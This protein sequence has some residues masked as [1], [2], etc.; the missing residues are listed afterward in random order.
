LIDETPFWTLEEVIQRA[1]DPVVV[2]ST[3]SV[4]DLVESSLSFPVVTDFH[5]L[6][7][8]VTTLIVVGGGTMMDAAKIMSLNDGFD[9]IAIPS[10]WGSGAEVS[11]I[12]VFTENGEKKHI[13]DDRL[14]PMARSSIPGL[15]ERLSES[16]VQYGCGDA[17]SHA[18]EGSVS[19]LGILE[20][21]ATGAALMNEMLEVGLKRDEQWFDFSA[22]ACLLQASTGVG[23][24]HGIAHTL[25]PILG[26]GQS[27]GG[28]GH[29]RL[30]S[31]ILWPVFDRFIRDT[32][33]WQSFTSEHMVDE[34]AISATL[35]SLFNRDDYLAIRPHL[36]EA[37]KLIL[38]HPLTR[39]NC[40]LVRSG[41]I[42]RFTEDIV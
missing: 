29:A 15:V 40:S 16:L 5:L 34:S 20:S 25:E 12:S 24:I 36:I 10:V 28:W 41:D 27:D 7:K 30:C 37:W 19:P 26:T 33:K 23:L 32:E 22:R 1:T 8:D 3:E 6:P 39:I 35:H 13:M 17:W 18:V 38:R 42:A 4:A 9:V 14:L 2:I 11:P 31:T 21:R